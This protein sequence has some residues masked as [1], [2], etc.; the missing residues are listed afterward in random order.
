MLASFCTVA[1]GKNYIHL[2]KLLADDLH[3][4][5]LGRNFIIFTDNPLEFKDKSN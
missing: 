4:F 5:A 1:F 2:S 3:K